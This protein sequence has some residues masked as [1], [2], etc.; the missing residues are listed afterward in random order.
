MSCKIF[1][2]LPLLA[3]AGSASA[4]D[5][6]VLKRDWQQVA[7][8]KSGDCEA[9]V[10]TN[11]QIVYIYAVGL[12]ADAP[13]RY[14]LTNGDMQPIDWNIQAD[15]NGEWA[16]YYTPY[17]SPHRDGSV[18][19]AITTERCSLGL[20]F[21]WRTGVPVIDVDGTRHLE[22]SGDYADRFLDY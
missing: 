8:D 19:V 21:Q 9:E 5:P 18:N 3:L 11:G 13:G 16:R 17:R 22:T 4:Y 15:G 2:V 12:G 10:R 1:L 7:Y 20:A 6:I 14:H